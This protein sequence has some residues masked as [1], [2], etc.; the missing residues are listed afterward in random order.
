MANVYTAADVRA[1]I[2]NYLADKVDRKQITE[3]LTPLVW[4]EKGAAEA[5]DLGW[6]VALLLME[7]SRGDLT[8]EELREQLRA[9]AAPTVPA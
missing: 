5:V 8:E 1:M 6:S 4:E 2:K 7:A 9:L 3:W